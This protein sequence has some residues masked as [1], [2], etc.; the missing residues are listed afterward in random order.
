[1]SI[2]LIFVL[3]LYFQYHI[4]AVIPPVE[5]LTLEEKVG[6]LLMVH[7]N[8]KEANEDARRL[9]QEM[10]VGGIIY[11]NWAN[12]LEEPKQVWSLS[13]QLQ[14]MANPLPLLIAVD[15]EGG[16]VNRLTKGFTIFPGNYA[17][18][19]TGEY[20]WGRES[21]RII[22]EEL[23]RV[24]ISLNLAPVADV[25]HPFANPVIGLRSFGTDPEKV[26]LWVESALQGYKQAGLI[27][28][29]KHFPGHG[30]AIVDSHET[31]PVIPKNREE[32]HRVD[33]TPFR[34]LAQ[35]AEVV[36]TA[37]LM[38]PALDSENCIT[39]SKKVI[40]KLLRNE[41]NFQGVVMTDSLAMN[42][43][44]S[45]CPSLEEAAL[46]SLESGHDM[47]L[48][49]GKQL[50]A[51]QTGLE[52]S[53]DDV[54]R[55]HEFL[56][57]AVITGRLSEKRVDESVR[58]ILALKSKKGLFDSIPFIE[59]SKSCPLAKQIAHRALQLIKGDHLVPLYFDEEL[60]VVAPESLKE[61]ITQTSWR[62][63]NIFY[64]SQ[65]TSFEKIEEAM[66]NKPICLF[67]G[68]RTQQSPDQQ[69][70]FNYLRRSFPTLLAIS[71]GLPVD[72]EFLLS[73]DLLLCTHSPT[74]YSLQA[75]FEFLKNKKPALSDDLAKILG[76][77]IWQNECAGKKEGLTTWNQGE[78]FASLGIGHFIWFPE[79][80]KANFKQTFPELISFFNSKGVPLPE[81]LLQ[82]KGCPW[83]TREE[84]QVAQN[85]QEL[86]SLREIL[87][88]YVDLQIQFMVQRLYNALPILLR[89]TPKK[90]HSHLTFQF[91]RLARTAGGQYALLD[92]LNFKGEG[93]KPQESYQG[94]RWGLLQVLEQMEGKEL[95]FP[96]VRE[97]VDMAKNVLTRRV[98][99]S[100]PGRN[101]LRWLKGW[102]N[103]LETYLK[104]SETYD[105]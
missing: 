25:F 44:L 80:K 51:S 32:L 30:A 20:S 9:I 21:A 46:N 70:L 63:E 82:A 50:L 39:F 3:A 6:Q 33:L 35:Q 84:F 13:L 28:A 2:R 81:W 71:T 55:V 47:I 97:F 77:Q 38:V 62:H 16:I 100:P 75:A 1:M 23:K 92:Y 68:Y 36:L 17:L 89:H 15:Q 7:F 22:G 48:L 60:F 104:F 105:K 10:H 8:G 19:V 66:E 78:D 54:K 52:F 64:Y 90:D 45:Q 24:G 61:S 79:G 102:H 94:H 26:T 4:S 49:G 101:E 72:G 87:V 12:G 83:Q 76:N 42:A 18:G 69:E 31:L 95:G 34:N 99:K 74:P 41:W 14:Q 93:T 98:E 57:N 5:K 43:I 37:H 91:F 59:N 58:R 88:T 56:V 96:A 27:A 85:S 73:A 67:F 103:R 29:L 40:E 11:Y 53:I 86:Q 65:E